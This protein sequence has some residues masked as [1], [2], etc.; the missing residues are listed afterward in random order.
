M[1]NIPEERRLQVI[2]IYY[3]NLKEQTYEESLCKAK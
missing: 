3:E 2:T 1:R